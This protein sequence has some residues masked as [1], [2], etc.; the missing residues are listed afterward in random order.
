[1]IQSISSLAI[2]QGITSWQHNNKPIIRQ[3]A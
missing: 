2:V 3:K 1:M